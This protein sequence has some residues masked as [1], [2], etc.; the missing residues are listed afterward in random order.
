MKLY[1]ESDVICPINLE[2]ITDP[3]LSFDDGLIYNSPEWFYSTRKLTVRTCKVKPVFYDK[4]INNQD[5]DI[6]DFTCPLSKKIFV[7]PVIC[8]TDGKAYE[9]DFLKKWLVVF[10]TCPTSGDS[11]GIRITNLFF[12]ECK[13]FTKMLNTFKS[14]PSIDDNT[15]ISN[16]GTEDEYINIIFN[17][18]ASKMSYDGNIIDVKNVDINNVIKNI[19]NAGM[20]KYLINHISDINYIFKGITIPTKEEYGPYADGENFDH[21]DLQLIFVVLLYDAPTSVIRHILTKSNIDM[22]I[23]DEFENTPLH[24]ACFVSNTTATIIKDIIDKT[25]DLDICNG[26]GDRPIDLLR[27]N[28][29]HN[30]L[31]ISYIIRKGADSTDYTTPIRSSFS[32]IG[33]RQKNDGGFGLLSSNQGGGFPSVSLNF[34]KKI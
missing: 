24:V 1:E 14:L 29:G 6:S 21:E 20:L 28:H 3:I 4:I 34:F 8:V 10:K 5:F 27:K 11:I 15:L 25:S 26:V 22:N 12:S 17:S 32:F 31:L 19:N 13:L 2:K 9:L 18:H 16:V 7:N 33:P 23:Q 30:L